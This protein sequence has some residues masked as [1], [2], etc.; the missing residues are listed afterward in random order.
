ML[1]ISRLL[2]LPLPLLLLLLTHLLVP[3][4]SLSPL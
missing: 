2:P 1:P 4:P 3:W